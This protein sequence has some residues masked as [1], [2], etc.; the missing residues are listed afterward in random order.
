[1]VWGST[2][3]AL[4]GDS[5]TRRQNLQASY[6]TSWLPAFSS[7]C[8]ATEASNRS[9]CQQPPETRGHHSSSSSRLRFPINTPEWRNFGEKD[10][11]GSDVRLIFHAVPTLPRSLC[12]CMSQLCLRTGNDFSNNNNGYQSLCRPCLTSPP[13]ASN[14]L[15][16]PA[17]SN[18]SPCSF[19]Q[20]CAFD[21]SNE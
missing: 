15:V 19:R 9:T 4:G 10:D 13:V 3:N 18:P 14:I 6:I 7:G 2:K 21:S 20:S 1:M 8:G 12:V 11:G 17:Y 5:S 16:S